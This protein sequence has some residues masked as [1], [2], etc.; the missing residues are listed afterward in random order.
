[1]GDQ[2]KPSPVKLPFMTIVLQSCPLIIEL[3]FASFSI[4]N[5]KNA[6]LPVD[7]LLA[8]SQCVHL[9][10][11]TL[12][13]LDITDGKFLEQVF[14]KQIFSYNFRGFRDFFKSNFS[15]FF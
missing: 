12:S 8:I 14:F 7:E 15:D 4:Y 9:K 5:K 11:L 13:N 10:K 6:K 1:M 3:E 2:R